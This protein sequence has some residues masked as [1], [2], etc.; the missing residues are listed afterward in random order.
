MPKT[1]IYSWRLD[2]NLRRRL[3]EAARAARTSVARL[4]DR[5]AREWLAK[6]EAEEEAE[7]GAHACGG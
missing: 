2:P 3:E 7:Q 6:R 5:I 1:V 4:L